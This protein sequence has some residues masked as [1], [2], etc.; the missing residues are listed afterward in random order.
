VKLKCAGCGGTDWRT[1]PSRLFAKMIYQCL[2]CRLMLPSLWPPK[3]WAT[4][5]KEG[6]R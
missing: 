6:Q 2:R 5:G 3:Q 4:P 1:R